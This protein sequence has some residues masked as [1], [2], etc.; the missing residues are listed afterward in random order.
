MNS[1]DAPFYRINCVV[2]FKSQISN[3]VNFKEIQAINTVLACFNVV[4]FN[5]RLKH[6]AK[7]FYFCSGADDS[8]LCCYSGAHSPPAGQ[9][10]DEC[11]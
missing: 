8:A 11:H 7:N 10:T 9:C 4:L 5:A 2:T 6:I 1:A 3:S